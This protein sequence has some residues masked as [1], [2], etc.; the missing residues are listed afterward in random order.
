MRV[1]Q[2]T[3]PISLEQNNTYKNFYCHSPYMNELIQQ[4][5]NEETQVI[6]LTGESSTGKT[7]LLQAACH[8]TNRRWLYLNCET[9]DRSNPK[10]LEDLKNQLICID[11]IELMKGKKNWEDALFKLLLSN[12]NQ[13]RIS[14]QLPSIQLEREDLNSRLQSLLTLKVIKLTEQSQE[15]ALMFRSHN[16]GIPLS[17]ELIQWMQKNLPRDNKFLF[18]FIDSLDTESLKSKI[19]PSIALAKKLLETNLPSQSH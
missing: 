11:N 19:K 15:Q 14:S 10:I 13:L 3:L 12:T 8:Q 16:K 17:K 18:N 2:L 9:L 7:H 5:K 6:I 4:V 1:E